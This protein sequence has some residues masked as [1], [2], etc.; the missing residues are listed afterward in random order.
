V[1]VAGLAAFA[2]AACSGKPA[3][4]KRG[5]APT[6]I[7]VTKTQLTNFEQIETTLGQ[8]EALQDPKI[9][10]EVAGRIVRVTAQAGQSVTEGQLL[11]E[12]DAADI[13]EQHRADQAEIARLQ[14]LNA[15]QERLTAR[16]Q[17]LLA[18]NFISQNALDDAQAQQQALRSQLDAARARAALSANALRKTRVAAPFAGTIEDRIVDRGNYVKVG[19]PLFRL[20]SNR[21]LRAHLPFPE[22]A[23][24]RLHPGQ[25]VRLDSP[26]LPGKPII[27][28]IEEIRPIVSEAGRALDVIARIDNPDGALKGGG[29]VDA[30]VVLGVRKDAV[31]VPEQAVVLRPSGHVVYAI[32]DG[33]AQQR[34]I[35]VGGKNAGMV[36]V[37]SGLQAGE[38]VALDGAGFLSQGAAV[39]VRDLHPSPASR[40]QENDRRKQPQ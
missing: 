4:Q 31:T 32:V 25:P 39:N 19:D 26:L 27:G 2:L 6:L 11:A 9:A 1:L 30:T 35:E 10:A 17:E 14:A 34:V 24:S 15:Q 13:T 28:E 23:A 37:R 36:E 33:K 40:Q 20:V 16:Q 38:T 21:Q 22:A 12:I 18:R 8:L 3:E 7:T 5:P 29:S